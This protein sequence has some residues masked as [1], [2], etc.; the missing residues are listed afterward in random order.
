MI[1]QIL[2]IQVV[3]GI[4]TEIDVDDERVF[5]ILIDEL[6]MKINLKVMSRKEGRMCR[7]A[8]FQPSTP[9]F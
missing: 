1:M 4:M 5:I 7:M 9:R 8:G 2:S 6:N 3:F